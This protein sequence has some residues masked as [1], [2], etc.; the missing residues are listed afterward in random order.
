M[1][2]KKTITLIVLLLFIMM[3]MQGISISHP[4][5]LHTSGDITRVKSLLA[6]SPW[7]EAYAHLQASSYASAS[8]TEHTSALL[9]GYLKRM[10]A[11]NWKLTYSDYSNYTA[12]MY[13]AAAAYQLALRYQLSGDTQYADAAV[14]IL[15]A[16]AANCKGILR[17][18]GYTNSIPDPNEYLINIQ[19]YQFANAAE[20]LRS[21]SG[22]SAADFSTFQSWMK[23]T[24]CSVAKL[25]LANHNNNIGTMHYWLNWDLA[26][27]T[28][29]LSIGILCDDTEL[30]DYAINYYKT[31]TS[32][33]GYIRNAVPY[34]HADADNGETLGQCEESGRDQG[35]ATL[36]VSLM[37]VFCQMAN[38]IGENLFA[39]DNHR[40]LNMAEYVAKYNLIND[41]SYNNSTNSSYSGLSSTDFTYVSSSFPYTSYSNPSYTNATISESQRGTKRPCWELFYGYAAAHNLSAAYCKKWVEQMR[42][43]NSYGCDGGSGDY[44]TNSGG[45][46]QLGYGTL[47]FARQTAADGDLID[48]SSSVTA[49]SVDGKTA[50]DVATSTT[51][52]KKQFTFTPSASGE[53]AVSFDATQEID[54]SKAFIVVEASS[55]LAKNTAKLAALSIDGTSGYAATSSNANPCIFSLSNGNK[56][57]IMNPLSAIP[58]ML[59]KYLVAETMQVSGAKLYL[60]STDA[61]AVT[62]YRVGFY[63]LGEILALYPELATNNFQ[64][65]SN[66]NIRIESSGTGGTKVAIKDA[67]KTTTMAISHL[68]FDTMGD[69]PAAYTNLDFRNIVLQSGE[70]A[71]REDWLS[72]FTGTFLMSATNYK[73]FPTLRNGAVKVAAGVYT[74]Y[75]DGVAPASTTV[76]SDGAKSAKYYDYTR[77]FKAGNNS[78][79]LPFDV[80]ADDLTALG[81]TAYTFSSYSDDYTHFASASGTITAGT[82][83]VIKVAEAGLYLIPSASTPNVITS[84]TNYYETV[85]G[86]D[87]YVGSFA[88]EIPSAYS[89]KYALDINADIFY[90]MGSST[91]TTYY[92]AFLSLGTAAAAKS[93]SFKLD[94][95]TGISDVKDTTNEDNAYYNLQGIKMEGIDL[96]HGI[97]IHHGKK[98]MK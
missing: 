83:M 70:T 61:N 79:V 18:N 22:W 37:G 63:N 7:S 11:T 73:Y 59:T 4:C 49:S 26:N 9:D 56:V 92:R 47:M 84:P 58:T 34:L 82:P 27:L 31:N 41:A 97:Y 89:N 3:K 33:T 54:R 32:E 29:V 76:T 52:S 30:I 1:N 66:N 93:F 51:N 24:F 35:H 55:N 48:L 45:F 77:A 95:S 98:V 72:R 50:Y 6:T 62:I 75:K 8:Y 13:D 19:A 68:M 94:D 81:L 43:Y 88:Y 39:Y 87:K 42:T 85:S 60:Y 65:V 44:G 10:D 69:L 28:A 90:A 12:A 46:D 25:F 20:L 57:E 23:S 2:I 67:T 64:Y 40:A 74:A 15:N 86:S 14:A 36:C 5:M 21:Y 17:V 78:C 38:N 96:P 53:F 16:W 80:T 71:T 91:Y